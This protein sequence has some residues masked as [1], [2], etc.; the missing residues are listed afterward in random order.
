MTEGRIVTTLIKLDVVCPY[1]RQRN[2]QPADKLKVYQRGCTTPKQ[3]SNIPHQL[4][5]YF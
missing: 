1:L 5:A 4:G 2:F 3:A